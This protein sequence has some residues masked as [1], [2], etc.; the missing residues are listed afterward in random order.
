[1]LASG[2]RRLANLSPR[3]LSKRA[4]TGAPVVFCCPPTCACVCPS[5]RQAPQRQSRQRD[6]SRL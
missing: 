6:S 4:A 2:A 1:A 3:A 5:G